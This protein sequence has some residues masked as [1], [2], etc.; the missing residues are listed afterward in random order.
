MIAY[1]SGMLTLLK[2][3]NGNNQTV[4]GNHVQMVQVGEGGQAVVAGEV[5]GS[6]NV[7]RG[8]RAPKGTS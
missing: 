3:K 8:S 7:K 2:I 4:I 5:K 1:Q 6:R